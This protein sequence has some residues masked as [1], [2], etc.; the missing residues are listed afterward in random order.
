MH[1]VSSQRRRGMP[2]RLAAEAARRPRA[3]RNGRQTFALAPGARQSD[4]NGASSV[5]HTRAA[6]AGAAETA[7]RL[8]S[9]YQM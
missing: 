3:G 8:D 1:S 2:I 4:S 7:D 5:R 6:L 9:L